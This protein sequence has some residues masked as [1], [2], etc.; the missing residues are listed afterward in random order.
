MVQTLLLLLELEQ[1][2]I[3]AK[4]RTVGKDDLQKLQGRGEALEMVYKWVMEPM[5]TVD[6][7]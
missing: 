2:K 1:A 5:D 7:P 3:G 6:N 4:L